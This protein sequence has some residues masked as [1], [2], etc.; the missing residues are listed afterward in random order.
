MLHMVSQEGRLYLTVVI[1]LTLVGLL[2]CDTAY[3]IQPA[4]DE[5]RM[6]AGS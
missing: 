3:L 4:T 6:S 5:Q 1:A 2:L